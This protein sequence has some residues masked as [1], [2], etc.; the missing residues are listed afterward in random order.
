MCSFKQP[1]VNIVVP[2]APA[3]CF[4]DCR[5]QIASHVIGHLSL[6]I[7]HWSL[8]IGHWSFVTGFTGTND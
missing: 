2:L 6:V 4:N 3:C 1:G 5:Y 8:V 7:G